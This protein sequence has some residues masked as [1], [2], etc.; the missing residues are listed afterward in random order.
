M[1][2]VIIPT[3]TDLQLLGG[4]T[5]KREKKKITLQEN[6]EAVPALDMASEDL[7]FVASD[8]KE[9]FET[10]ELALEQEIHQII[11]KDEKSRGVMRWDE[12]EAMPAPTSLEDEFITRK[13]FE[14]MMQKYGASVVMSRLLSLN[15]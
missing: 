1:V 3:D 12:N 8:K 14:Y 15:Y 5:P 11:M 4:G 2:G 7:G 6:E 9:A 13:L 10:G